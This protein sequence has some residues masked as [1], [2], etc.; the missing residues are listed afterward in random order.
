MK[1]LIPSWLVGRNDDVKILNQLTTFPVKPS[2]LHSGMLIR[3]ISHGLKASIRP[4]F[5]KDFI[6]RNACPLKR[7]A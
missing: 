3:M 2:L 6:E 7:Y 4:N 5:F 1:P